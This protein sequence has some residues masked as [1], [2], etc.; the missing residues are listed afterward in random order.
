MNILEMEIVALKPRKDCQE[1][2]FRNKTSFQEVYQTAN[3]QV[4]APL[5]HEVTGPVN[6]LI[7]LVSP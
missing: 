1:E 4:I 3:T 2:T 5:R 7:L 6:R